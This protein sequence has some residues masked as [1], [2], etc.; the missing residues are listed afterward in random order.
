ME[1]T[2]H[3]PCYNLVLYTY[4]LQYHLN[5]ITM[6]NIHSNATSGITLIDPQAISVLK[7]HLLYYKI[8]QENID[9]KQY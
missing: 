5:I 1:C 3:C 4:T 2:L 8:Y 9:T 6:R 7:P